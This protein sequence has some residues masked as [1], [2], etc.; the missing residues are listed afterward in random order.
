VRNIPKPRHRWS[1]ASYDVM[2]KIDEKRSRTIR[3]QVAGGAKGRVL[4]IGCGTGLNFEHYDWGQVESVDA[5]EPDTYMLR[6]AEEKARKLPL[7]A[8][9]K[10]RVQEAPAEDMP[11]ADASFDTVVSNLVLCTVF[12][13]QRSLA[14]VQRVLRPGG[15]FRLF[16]HVAADG[17]TGTVQRFIQPVYGWMAAGCQLSRDTESAV[18]AAGFQLNVLERTS[19]GPIWP[20]FIAVGTKAGAQL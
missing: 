20:A 15:E 5:T 6:K 11:F 7:D 13:P 17:F 1:A 14:E 16:E 10:V 18:R 8:R 3:Q 2:E 12:D 9:S 19:L 4:E